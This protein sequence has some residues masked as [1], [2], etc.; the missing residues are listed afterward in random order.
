MPVGGR[1]VCHERSE[2]ERRKFAEPKPRWPRRGF[3]LGLASRPLSRSKVLAQPSTTPPLNDEPLTLV[4]PGQS[5]V[6]T[7]CTMVG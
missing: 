2:R 4:H 3:R 5:G 1:H 6:P 7:D